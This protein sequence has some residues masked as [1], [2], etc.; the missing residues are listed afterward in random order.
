MRTQD[1]FEQ[2]IGLFPTL[3][4]PLDLYVGSFP[5]PGDP[6]PD[7]EVDVPLLLELLSDYYGVGFHAHD[8]IVHQ[9]HHDDNGGGND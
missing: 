8:N 5:H 7:F 2:I 1:L 3:T 4:E 9:D 6:S